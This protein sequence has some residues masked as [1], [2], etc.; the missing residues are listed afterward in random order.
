MENIEEKVDGMEKGKLEVDYN[1]PY[2][3]KLMNALPNRPRFTPEE[4]KELGKEAKR[5]IKDMER[6]FKSPLDYVAGAVT[7]AMRLFFH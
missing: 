1:G 6:K 2:C 3:L 5:G 7:Y 4:L